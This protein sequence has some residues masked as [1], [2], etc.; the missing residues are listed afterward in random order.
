VSRGAYLDFDDMPKELKTDK[1]LLKKME[2]HK[3]IKL[4]FIDYWLVFLF[5]YL[6]CLKHLCSWKRQGPLMKLFK[7]GKK[8]VDVELNV[9]RL[10]RNSNHISSYLKNTVITNK[11]EWHLAHS[12]RNTINI[13]RSSSSECDSAGSSIGEKKEKEKHVLNFKESLKN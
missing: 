10:V 1:E 9:V 2:F 7:K 6:P 5:Y 12:E 8:K 13:D 11:V 4:R 3:F